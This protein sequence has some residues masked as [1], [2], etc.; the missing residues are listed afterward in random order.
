MRLEFTCARCFTVFAAFRNGKATA[1]A[2][3]PGCGGLCRDPVDREGGMR[4]RQEQGAIVLEPAGS[5]PSARFRC[6]DCTRE[7]TAR[8]DGKVAIVCPGCGSGRSRQV[9][10]AATGIG[11]GASRPLTR[12][13]R[14]RKRF[15]TRWHANFETLR[16]HG[17]A[18]LEAMGPLEFDEERRAEAQALIETL[19]IEAEAIKEA[20]IE[21]YLARL[22]EHGV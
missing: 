21:R 2:K 5:V 13:E 12:A 3:C 1:V 8:A 10:P 6:V 11:L 14:K 4:V 20:K 22:S 19:V 7:F 15:V 16:K 9:S 17:D 18:L